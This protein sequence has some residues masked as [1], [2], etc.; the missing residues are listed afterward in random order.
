[1]AARSSASALYEGLTATQKK[2]LQKVTSYMRNN[3]RDV[4]RRTGNSYA[5]H[6]LHVA[7]TLKEANSDVSLL[8]VAA[9]HDLL[10]HPDGSDLLKSAPL[11]SDEKKLVE[12]MFSLR[13]LHIYTSENDL[14]QAIDAFMSEPKLALL[15]MAHRVADVR[16]IEAFSPR[17]RKQ[18]ARE[19]LHMYSAL[20]GRLGMHAWRI[21]MEDIC[22]PI[23]QPKIAKNLADKYEE[24]NRID[25]MC[26]KDTAR[27]LRAKLK[28]AGVAHDVDTRRKGLYSTYRKMVIK[29]RKYEELTDRLAIRI[30]V[31]KR[32]DCYEALG[33][34]HSCMH[35]IP[36]KLKDY[37]GAPK[38]NGYQ[39][40]HTVVYPVPGVTEQPIEIQIRSQEMH[41]H[42]E[43]GPAAH[44]D[45]KRY[46]YALHAKPTRVNLLKNLESLREET[47]S[48]EQFAEALRSYFRED[49][50]AVFDASNNLYH[51][52]KPATVLDFACHAY[53]KQWSKMKGVVIN[54][55]KS[56]IEARLQDGD[57]VDI[58]FGREKR[59]A[60]EWIDMCAQAPTKRTI[61]QQCGQGC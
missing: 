25:A 22:F 26:L 32:I 55:R 10:V 53:P 20:A 5:E 56:R 23:I 60:K 49:H 43:Y 42:C 57:I 61:K 45:Y 24:S 6:C 8:S 54:G 59:C 7:E 4:P 3:L 37:I 9:L 13:R 40:I 15:R 50:L 30:V 17:L 27:F 14:D 44:A 38:E 58:H 41:R 36:G 47:R 39:S 29:A 46:M 35:P 21:E 16:G 18:I 48:P 28:A 2:R 1:M 51:L 52:K 11:K 33:V 34:V 19:T 31:P 12:Q